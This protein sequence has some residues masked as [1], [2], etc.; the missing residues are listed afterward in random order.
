MLN[1][2]RNIYA[3]WSASATPVVQVLPEA[4]IIP[5]GASANE[6][7]KI[8]NTAKKYSNLYEHEN[9]PLPGF[10]LF[11]VNRKGYSSTDMSWLIIDP[12]G[13][14]VRI[15]NQNL[16]EI[17]FVT[18]ITEGLIQEKCL[19]A[20]DDTS[21]KM[22][23]VPISSPKYIEAVQNTALIEG[24]VEL[25]DVQIGD[26][27]LLQN[28]LKGV[29]KGVISLYGPVNNYSVREEYKP[30]TLL[31]RQVVEITPGKYH[32]Q[33]DVKILKVVNKAATP[34]TREQSVAEMNTQIALGTAFFTQGTN[35]SGRYY[36]I[37]GMITFT[38]VHAVPKP[39]ISFVEVDKLEATRL[40]YDATAA[41]DIGILALV[42]PSGV[43]VLDLPYSSYS[44]TTT[45][46]GS[47]HVCELKNKIEDAEKLILKST[48]RSYFSASKGSTPQK[49]DNFTKFY[50]IVKH[51]KGDTFT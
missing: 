1:I 50:K 22:T 34:S 15:T 11:K 28:G 37:Q 21:T 7:R 45:S 9:V 5:I 20:R 14:L 13:F 16:E 24:K 2:A 27:V 43:S 32:H 38:S 36:G 49:L 19:W 48:R 46:I 33:T 3:G 42:N 41:S 17:L 47:F 40:F 39:T 6:K 4:E 26:T 12:R 8:D 44:G 30:Q 10:T 51:V 29:Y 25:K 31:R 35:M 23:L 18:G